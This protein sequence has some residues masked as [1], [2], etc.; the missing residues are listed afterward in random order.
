MQC[1][2]Y[3][4]ASYIVDAMNGFA[5]QETS[6]PYVCLITD[7]ASTD[8]APGV[9]KQYMAKHFDLTDE[10]TAKKEDT[11]DYTL[12]FARHKTQKNCY[13]A[14]LEL[15]YNHF[16]INKSRQ[17]YWARW[18]GNAE[19]IAF[20]EGD[21]YW[22]SSVKLQKQVDFLDN[23]EDF[24][25]CGTN[26][27]VLW[28]DYSHWP[29]YFN[30]IKINRELCPEEI[31]GNWIFPTASIVV[32]RTVLDNYPAWTKKI[33]SGDITLLLIAMSRGRIYAMADITCVYRKL[34]ESAFAKAVIS[35]KGFDPDKLQLLLY[36]SF[37]EYTG[38][39][40][41]QPISNVIQRLEGNVR[42]REIESHN[43]IAQF[44][45]A[46][47]ILLSRIFRSMVECLK[48]S[49]IA[50]KQSGIFYRIIRKNK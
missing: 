38:E 20:C 13:F 45:M 15:K 40:Y 5:M 18:T 23:N 14:I 7:D 42:R 50:K 17:P 32:R 4:H 16:Q 28:E 24:T 25:C 37:K 30:N 19:Y 11:D 34:I 44:F 29:R 22:I 36:K 49:I 33:S 39:R 47:R 2:T 41:A 26:G 21:D 27:L 8:G 6:F 31:I 12:T 43:I 35:K 1:M 48:T 10:K 9:I 46:P 3:N